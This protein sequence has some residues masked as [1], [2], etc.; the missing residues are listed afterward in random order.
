[1][2]IARSNQEHHDHGHLKLNHILPIKKKAGRPRLTWIKQA[3]KYMGQIGFHPDEDYSNI[4]K[5]ANDLD[6]WRA[7][8][9]NLHSS[10]QPSES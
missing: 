8:I 1:M 10:R 2:H 4:I 6:D 5:K 3:R 7:K 9:S